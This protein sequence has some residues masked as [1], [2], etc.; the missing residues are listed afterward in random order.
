MLW[1]IVK[2]ELF[3]QFSSLR[4]G[5]ATALTVSLMVVNAI[6]YIGTYETQQ[7]I[8][9][10]QVSEALQEIENSCDNLY[11]LV[12]GGP[13]KLYKKPSKFSFCANGS[14]EYLPQVVSG[15]W[16]GWSMAVTSGVWRLRYDVQP[17]LTGA[18]I[19][20]NFLKID[21]GLIVTFVFSFLSL[22]FTFDSISG[23]IEKGTLRL[24]LSNAIARRIVLNAK[25]LSTL[26]SLGTLFL[27]G[28]LMNLLLLYT[29]GTIQLTTQDLSRIA[30]VFLVFFVYLSLFIAL[31]LLVSARSNRAASSLIILLLCWVI[32]VLLIPSTLGTIVSY[33]HRAPNPLDSRRSPY[34]L[35]NEIG[36]YYVARGLLDETPSRTYPP[37]PAT[38][39]WAEFLNS[40][41]QTANRLNRELLT[42]QIREIQVAR[43][44]NR[45][46]PAAIVQYAL[47]S[48][49]GTGFQRHLQFLI[50]V[51][52]YAVEFNNFLIDTDRADLESLHVP[53]VREGMSNKPVSF[54]RVPK[55]EDQFR[56]TDVFKGAIL[57]AML[58][59]LFF[60]VLFMAAHV[61]FQSKE[62]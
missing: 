54:E 1:H 42:A 34:P 56:L 14:E 6:G 47:E 25:F 2:R 23:E 32:W 5:I 15:R 60:G 52:N 27:I 12:E 40:E 29:S 59:F 53:F 46:S 44:F 22:V 38:Q 13:G 17:T 31:G 3:E 45:I 28:V 39:L 43:D 33:F 11:T 18:H 58:L 41:V 24:T 7:R 48:L 61:S 37:T 20:P 30:G 10:K 35:H 21:W 62:I 4:F 51:E 55:F 9:R 26:I 19:F 50:N 57:E 49:S 36:E 8:Y 16:S